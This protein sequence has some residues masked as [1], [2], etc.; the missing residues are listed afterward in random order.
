M[1]YDCFGLFL[2]PFSLEYIGIGKQEENPSKYIQKKYFHQA[3]VVHPFNTSTQ[4]AET[5][6]HEFKAKPG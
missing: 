2:F 5:D 3:V 1:F 6:F 4:A